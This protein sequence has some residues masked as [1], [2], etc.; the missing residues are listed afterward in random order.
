MVELVPRCPEGERPLAEVPST[1][2]NREQSSP[3]RAD[4]ASLLSSLMLEEVP[5]GVWM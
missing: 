2:L 3:P 4:S 1:R 5:L